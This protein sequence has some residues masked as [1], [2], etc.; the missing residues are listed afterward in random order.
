MKTEVCRICKQE[1]EH[2]C[3]AVREGDYIYH[4]DCYYP[5]TTFLRP[6]EEKG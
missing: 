1:I 6:R 3:E 2:S 5:S 4:K